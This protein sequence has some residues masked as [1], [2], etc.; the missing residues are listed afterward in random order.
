MSRILAY[1]DRDDHAHDDALGLIGPGLRKTYEWRIERAA[2]ATPEEV[3]RRHAQYELTASL[4]PLVAKAGLPILA[5]TDAGYLNSF[6]YPGQGL[7]DELA[8]YVEA[9]LTPAQALRSAVVTGP[10]F[11]GKSARYGA[12]EPGKAADILILNANPLADI[13]ATRAI[14]TVVLHGQTYNR[15]QLDRL[16]AEAR[17]AAAR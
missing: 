4:M 9:G 3:A 10:A 8:R 12:L 7:H 2:K 14:R 5:G 11:L 17:R 16:L 13:A 6:N 1:L 15:A